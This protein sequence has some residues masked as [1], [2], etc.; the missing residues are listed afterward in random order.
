MADKVNHVSLSQSHKWLQTSINQWAWE[1]YQI[2]EKLYAEVAANNMLNENY[3]VNH[4]D[5]VD[6]RLEQAGLRLANELNRIFKDGF[7]DA[8]VIAEAPITNDGV[9]PGYQPQTKLSDVTNHVG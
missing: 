2:S 9:K 5:I 7:P 8:H 4:I 6:T 1:S 3:Y